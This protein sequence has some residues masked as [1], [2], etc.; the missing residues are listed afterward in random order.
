MN[1]EDAKRLLGIKLR[2]LREKLG[3]SQ[4]RFSSLI[5]LDATN[6]S[7]IETGKSFP[8]FITFCNIIEVL[9][10]EPNNLLNFISFNENLNVTPDELFEYEHQTNEKNLDAMNLKIYHNLSFKKKKALYKI[11]RSLED[12]C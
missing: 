3:Y 4:D 11:L 8:S 10:I 2:N 7:R 6:L 12:L 9:K 1:E 5:N